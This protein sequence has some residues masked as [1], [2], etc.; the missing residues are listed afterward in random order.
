MQEIRS[1]LR[2]LPAEGRLQAYLTSS[3]PLVLAAI[4]SAPMTLSAARPDG[5]RKLEPFIDPQQRTAAVLARAETADPDTTQTLRDVDALRQMYVL[6]VGSVRA[7]I[8]AAAP[9]TFRPQT[10]EVTIHT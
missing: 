4:E 7:E 3:D 10:A 8:L 2:Q 9:L 6:A 5:S 1:Q